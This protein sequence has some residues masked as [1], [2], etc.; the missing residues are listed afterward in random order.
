MKPLRAAWLAAAI[1][2][3]CVPAAGAG[4]APPA[5]APEAPARLSRRQAIE[6]AWAHNPGLAAAREQ[7]AQA[8]ARIVEARALPDPALS[9]EY[10]DESGLL[11]PGSS[12]ARVYG[13]D[14]AVPFPTKIRLG[15]KAATDLYRSAELDYQQAR[16]QLAADTVAAYDALLVARRHRS[17]LEQAEALAEDFLA[18]TKARFAAGTV[19]EIDVV[20][21][22]VDRAQAGNALIAV[23]RQ[24]ATSRSA[25][26]R[27]LGQPLATP[28]ELTDPLSV[29]P[30]L[31]PLTALVQL[32]AANRPDLASLAARRQ[33]ASAATKLARSFWLPDFDF[34]L[35]RNTYRGD[36]STFTTT[37]GISFP[38]FF[39]QH[40]KG[41]IAE[42]EH[43]EEELSASSSDLAAQAA[44]E[45]RSAYQAADA[46]RRQAIYLQDQLLPE[47][48]RAYDIA[49]K[50]YSLGGL[51]ALDLLD[52]KRTLLDAEGEFADALGAANDSRADLERAV[53]T[54]LP[55]ANSGEPDDEN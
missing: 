38:L 19:P 24:L 22:E 13:L 20:K 43:Y 37:A 9:A 21:A 17:D 40:K 54:T 47:A 15:G 45:V 53:G 36:V 2:T 42:A 48:Q 25:L 32:A 50:S 1:I 31:P 52:S 41:E 26:N 23:E 33:A 29:P 11:S 3:V 18:K 30:P 4:T 49:S 39:W 8:Q 55:A 27:L 35:A 5:D 51:S 44:L 7:V 10:D 28:L 6:Q 34:G 16:Q 46:A 14:L 12:P